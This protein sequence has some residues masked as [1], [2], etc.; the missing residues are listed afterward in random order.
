MVGSSGQVA[1]DIA[2][3]A[4]ASAS[5]ATIKADALLKRYSSL[6]GGAEAPSLERKM[7]VNPDVRLDQMGTLEVLVKRANNLVAKDSNGYSDPFA[8]ITVHGKKRFRTR[9]IHKSLDPVWDQ[10]GQYIGQ[11]KHFLKSP[12]RINLYDR[13]IFSANDPLGHIEVDLSELIYTGK[14]S[15]R[16]EQLLGVPHG[17]LDLTIRFVQTSVA[18]ASPGPVAAAANI[19]LQAAVLDVP[20]DATCLEHKRDQLLAFLASHP[21]FFYL[22]IL[23]VICV[24][25]WILFLLVLFPLKFGIFSWTALGMTEEQTKLWWVRVNTVLCSLFTWQNGLTFPWRLS[26]AIH[27]L[28]CNRRK[29]D[30]GLDLYGRPTEAMFFHL[31][32]GH[33]AGIIALLNGAVILQFAQQIFRGFYNTY[34]LSEEGLPGVPLI[35]SSFVGSIIC[36]IAGGIYQFVVLY[37]LHGAEPE[38]FPPSA[39]ITAIQHFVHQWR[40]NGE[41]NC[42]RLVKGSVVE[43]KEKLKEEKSKDGGEHS[44]LSTAPAQVAPAN[45]P[46]TA[47]VAPE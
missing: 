9:I 13:D 23:W 7:S 34:E 38:R 20:S 16:Q 27:L 35:M 30:P 25:S 4:S 18:F 44:M 5:I 11:L 32:R 42:C 45:A 41:R 8:V 46:A 19:A 24:V 2:E 43:F 15:L 21:I 39:V 6:Q 22:T 47:K 31:P 1:V 36:A 26:C 14:I 28:P 12:M 37:K 17:S 40:D 10:T 3:D 33:R 29:N